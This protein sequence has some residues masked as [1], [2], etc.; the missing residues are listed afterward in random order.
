MLTDLG[1]VRSGQW[2]E[3]LGLAVQRAEGMEFGAQA[4]R[5]PRLR[6]DRLEPGDVL[7]DLRFNVLQMKSLGVLGGGGVG[8]EKLK[9]YAEGRVFY[10]ISL[11]L[12]AT[13]ALVSIDG[14][15]RSHKDFKQLE[16]Y[17]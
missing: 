4:S 12:P 1:W 3:G 15:S 6:I 14:I 16:E 13:K 5:R 11:Q 9:D 17:C 10:P 2:E 7:R 8:I